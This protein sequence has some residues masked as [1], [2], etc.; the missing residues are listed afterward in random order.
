MPRFVLAVF[1][2][3]V[4]WNLP[5]TE[6]GLEP[7]LEQASPEFTVH[8]AASELT[9]VNYPAEH[10]GHTDHGIHLGATWI[11]FA[12]A[13]AG[14]LLATVFYGLRKLD[15]ED[16]RRQ[17]APL[18]RFL[19]NKWWFDE[20][21][22]FLFVRPA[23]K[24]SGWVAEID[25]QGIDWVADGAAKTTAWVSR[26]DDWIDRTFVDGLIDRFAAWTYAVGLKLRSVQTGNLRQY[27]VWIAVGTVGLFVLVSLYW[28]YT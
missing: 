25:K 3:V 14:F 18:H 4:G 16:A 12:M 22:A 26:I 20:L 6:L 11:A 28:N 17:F 10:V 2:V 24:V 5:F 8:P 23:L 7:L 27:V 21:Y 1:A 15:P 19:L 9:E 13:A